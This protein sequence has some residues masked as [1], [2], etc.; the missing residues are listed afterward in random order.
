MVIWLLKKQAPSKLLTVLNNWAVV[1]GGFGHEI[2]GIS[3]A[4]RD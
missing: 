2:L 3:T 1:E 4:E